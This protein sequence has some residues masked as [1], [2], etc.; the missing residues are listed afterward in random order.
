MQ[1]QALLAQRLAVVGEVDHRRVVVGHRLQR[2]DGA[3][4][5]VVGVQQRIVVGVGDQ[6]AAAV[7]QVGGV[8]GRGEAAERG[9]VALEVAGA[10]AAELV[11]HHHA[12]AGLGA[13]LRGQVLQQDLVHAASVLAQL[14]ILGVVQVLDL[15]AVAHALAAGLVVA[16][17]RGDAGVLEHVQQRLVLADVALVVVV[18]A[19]RR[20]HARHRH[21]GAGAAGVH[22]GEVDHVALGQLRRGLPCI[23][24]EAPVLRA[25]GFAQHHHQQPRL[26]ARRTRGGLGVVLQRQFRRLA[27]GAVGLEVLPQRDQVVDRRGQVAD[28]AMVAHHRRQVL[29]RQHRSDAAQRQHAHQEAGA[30]RQRLQRRTPDQPHPPQH[31]DRQRRVEQQR[32][33]QRRGHQLARFLVVGGQHVAQHVRVQ[34]DAVA[35]HVVRGE[36]GGDQQHRQHRLGDAAPQQ[37]AQQQA[38]HRQQQQEQRQRQLHVAAVAAH[39]AAP[40]HAV[41]GQGEERAGRQRQH[42]VAQLRTP[43]PPAGAG[44]GGR[45]GRGDG[46]AHAAESLV[47]E[48]R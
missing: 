37:Q 11:Q 42:L 33:D 39:R 5:Q 48:G 24:V 20:E 17:Q 43:R 10:V 31:Q 21:L 19:E 28:L 38:V 45:R 41:A 40:E 4:Q 29:E 15:Q 9:R 22:V 36:R 14:R 46:M 16:P 3:R 6:F 13:H 27:R 35:V 8:A 12:V 18:A 2:V 34:V 26:A 23:A 25:G 44:G 1:V 47:V 7:A 30:D 32:R